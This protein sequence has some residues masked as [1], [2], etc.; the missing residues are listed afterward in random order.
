MIF[1]FALAHIADVVVAFGDTFPVSVPA[2]QEWSSLR[3]ARAIVALS[4]DQSFRWCHPS[5][6]PTPRRGG[7]RRLEFPRPSPLRVLWRIPFLRQELN[8]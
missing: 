5:S 7:T 1:R 6:R 4:C 8:C 3:P 2:R